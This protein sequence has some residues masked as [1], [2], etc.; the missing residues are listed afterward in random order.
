MLQLFIKDFYTQRKTSYLI[1]LLLLPGLLSFVKNIPE[2]NYWLQVILYSLIIGFIA[3]Y[4]TSNTNFSTN[5]SDK[6]QNWLLLSL[7]VTRQNIVNAKF[8]MIAF[9]WLISYFYVIIVYYIGKNFYIFPPFPFLDYNIIIGSLCI[10]YVLLSLFYPVFFAFGFR[11]AGLI[12]LSIFSLIIIYIA[13]VMIIRDFS[14]FTFSTIENPI[15]PLVLFT[16]I[17]VTISYCL[18]L[19]IYT[20]KDF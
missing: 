16:L 8:I 20:K 1:P 9:W 15:L 4:L 10:T 3:Y 5:E 7:P 14:S 19:F 11:M 13:T 18:S 6:N 12:G 2:Q 17:F